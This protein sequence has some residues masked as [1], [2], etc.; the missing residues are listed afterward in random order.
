MNHLPDRAAPPL[1]FG[2]AQFH[3]LTALRGLAAWWVVLFHFDTYL[4]PYL[5][6]WAFYLVSKGYLAVDLFFCLSG[7]VIFFNYG[8]LNVSSAREIRVFYL[9]RFAKIYPLHFFT[10]CLYAL[11]VGMLLLSHHG[12]PEQRFSGQGLL[13]NLFLVQD[14]G[15]AQD[16]TW[17]VPSWSIS[18]EFAAYLLFPIAVT[19][20]RAS[21]GRLAASLLAILALLLLLNLFFAPADFQFGNAIPTLGVVRCI[22]QFA[23]GALLAR[24]YLAKSLTHPIVRPSLFALAGLFLAAGLW[25]WESALVPLAWAAL[26]FAMARGDRKS[27]FLNQRWLVFVG[28]ISYATYMIHYF[29]RDI[30]KL[31]FVHPGQTTPLY[32]MLLALLIVMAA[33]IGLYFL[34]ERPA[35][36]YLTAKVRVK[37]ISAGVTGQIA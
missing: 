33:S 36:K 11:L 22:T 18:A 31:A 13:M 2:G 14:W 4:L 21:G 20:I 17:N 6:S 9:K 32:D 3:S 23:I 16:L 10:I 28:E 37:K 12:I 24:L 19:A 29:V 34:I 30:F 25:R 26:V 7:F 27:G 1:R 5:P 35:Q 8:N 15:G